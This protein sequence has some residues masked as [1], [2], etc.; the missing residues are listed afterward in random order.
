MPPAGSMVTAN[1]IGATPFGKAAI[2]ELYSPAVG[3]KNPALIGFP[4][5][6]TSHNCRGV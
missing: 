6:G 5:F 3:L 1:A 4:F 2:H